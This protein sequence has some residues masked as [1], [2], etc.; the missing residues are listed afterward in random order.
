M[1]KYKFSEDGSVLTIYDSYTVPKADFQKTLN[2]IKSIHGNKKIF[3]R[4]D[5]SLKKE[6]R[7]TMPSMV[8]TTSGARRR[9]VISTTHATNPSGFTA[10]SARWYGHSSNNLN[11]AQKIWLLLRPVRLRC[12]RHRRLW[13]RSLLQS[14]VHRC[15]CRCAGRD[16]L[17]DGQEIL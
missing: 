9:T 6:W 8:S 17:P 1:V 4:T 16:G 10:S 2:Q 5:N 13:L 15:L 7:L 3:E 14:L 11:Y 12:G